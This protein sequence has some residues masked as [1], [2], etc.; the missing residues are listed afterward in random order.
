MCLPSHSALFGIFMA[1]PTSWSDWLWWNLKGRNLW[2][3]WVGEYTIDFCSTSLAIDLI[4]SYSSVLL[5]EMASILNEG[6]SLLPWTDSGK[7]AIYY[8]SSFSFHGACNERDMKKAITFSNMNQLRTSLENKDVRST[9]W[10]L[11]FFCGSRC[12][13]ISQQCLEGRRYQSKRTLSAS[14]KTRMFC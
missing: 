11:C 13:V 9:A 12:C 6:D 3:K 14:D 7:V 1:T 5:C 2:T 10:F 8:M 4:N